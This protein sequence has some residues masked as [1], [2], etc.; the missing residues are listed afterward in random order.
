MLFYKLVEPA[1]ART[2]CSFPLC[3][4]I[5]KPDIISSRWWW[6]AA[7]QSLLQE[8]VFFDNNVSKSNSS[9]QISNRRFISLTLS[10][11]E[12][13]LLFGHGF[14]PMWMTPTLPHLYLISLVSCSTRLSG[15]TDL[16]RWASMAWN[17]NSTKRRQVHP[18]PPQTIS[19][20]LCHLP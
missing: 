7:C 10:T 11:F 9:P 16:P 17:L 8:E 15:N 2:S 18:P 12:T 19:P 5:S 13:T 3:F 1:Q 4:F 6:G 20:W 14:P